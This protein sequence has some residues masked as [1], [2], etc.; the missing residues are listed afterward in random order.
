MVHHECWSSG[1]WHVK[2]PSETDDRRTARLRHTIQRWGCSERSGD[3]S[4]GLQLTSF[5]LTGD[6]QLACFREHRAQRL[7]VVAPL[8]GLQTDSRIIGIDFRPADGVLYGVG[9]Q[10]G[11]YTIDLATAAASN[12]VQMNQALVGTTSMST[13]TPPSTGCASCPTLDGTGA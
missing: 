11:V 4:V 13:S 6:H 10:G 5:A 9:D 2:A 7:R 12:R 8:T 3:R 1:R